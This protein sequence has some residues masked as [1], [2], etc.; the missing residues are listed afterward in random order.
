MQDVRQRIDQIILSTIRDTK[1]A[2]PEETTLYV[3]AASAS[4]L[5]ALVTALPPFVDIE[6]KY[7]VKPGSG[8][9]VKLTE[10]EK[11]T[12]LEDKM[13]GDQLSYLSNYAADEGYNN[14]LFTTRKYLES[15]YMAK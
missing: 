9:Y 5:D 14:A 10:H 4:I 3:T 6:S 1:T 11:K 7:E 12:K 15:L 8:V 2:S 13:D